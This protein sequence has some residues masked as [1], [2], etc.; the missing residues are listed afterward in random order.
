[1]RES[2]V[3]NLDSDGWNANNPITMRSLRPLTGSRLRCRMAFLREKALRLSLGNALADDKTHLSIEGPGRPFPSN[4]NMTMIAG[5]DSPHN[6]VLCLII[7]LDYRYTGYQLHQILLRQ[8]EGSPSAFLETAMKLLSAMIGFARRQAQTVALQG[9]IE[10]IPF[11]VPA[12]RPKVI[13]DLSVLISWLENSAFPNRPE[14]KTCLAINSLISGLLDEVLPPVPDTQTPEEREETV[15]NLT[16]AGAQDSRLSGTLA[17]AQFNDVPEFQ[18]S[19]TVA[20]PSQNLNTG[21]NAL[22]YESVNAGFSQ[23][24][25]GFLSCEDFADWLDGVNWDTNHLVEKWPL[26]SEK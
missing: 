4:T 21:P 16:T 24:L 8:N 2:L 3:N 7:Y 1:M 11:P 14:C 25:S 20:P 12:S 19:Q 15:T 17:V 26:F 5:S 22:T 23:D 13:R 18:L 6:C 9:S 10:G